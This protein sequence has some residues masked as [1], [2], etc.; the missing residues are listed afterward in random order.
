MFVGKIV[1]NS[2]A[3]DAGIDFEDCSPNQRNIFAWLVHMPVAIG[4]R[5]MLDCSKLKSD[6]AI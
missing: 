3:A 6:T 4:H 2:K 1:K 5:L